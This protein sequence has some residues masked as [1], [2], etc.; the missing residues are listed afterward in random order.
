MPPQLFAI[1][2]KPDPVLETLRE[3]CFTANRSY[4]YSY[5]KKKRKKIKLKLQT[6]LMLR[7]KNILNEI[8][9]LL[10]WF[11]PV[12]KKKH[13][14]LYMHTYRGSKKMYWHFSDSKSVG[15]FFWDTFLY[16]FMMMYI[17]NIYLFLWWCSWGEQRK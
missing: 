2:G 11:V 13:C 16:T 9:I 8:V 10:F 6:R 7:L 12:E 5:K 14:I 4:A 1:P 17:M 3:L 15:T